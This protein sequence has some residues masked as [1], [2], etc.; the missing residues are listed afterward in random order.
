MRNPALRLLCVLS[1]VVL[2]V[3]PL[4]ADENENR[5]RATLR[6]MQ[7]VGTAAAARMT[8]TNV[9]PDVAS[10][11]ALV[12]LLTPTYLPE[13]PLRDGWDTPLRYV[14][15]GPQSFQ[16]VSAGAD[17][18][19]DEKS[20]STA[21]QSE[22]LAA[23]AVYLVKRQ[24]DPG[25]FHRFWMA[26]GGARLEFDDDA[27]RELARPLVDAE[28]EKMKGMSPRQSFSYLRTS[29]TLRDME[30][31][32][33]FLDVYRLK[34]GRYP[35]AASMAELEPML[36][37]EF[38]SSVPKKDKWG[39]ELRYVPSPDGKSYRLI[40][41]GEDALF[42]ETS[43]AKKGWLASADDDAVVE[44][45]EI[46]RRWTTETQPGFGPRAKLQPKA[47]ALLAEADARLEAQDHAGAL[48][49][50]IDA[51][52]ADRAA[53]DLEALRRYAPPAFEVTAP[54]PESRAAATAAHIAALRQFLELHPGNADAE[55]DLVLLLPDAEAVA[56]AGEIVKRRPRDAEA[57]RLRSQLRFRAGQH[58]EALADLEHATT[59]EPGNGE[60]FYTAGVA[61]Y[62][63]VAKQEG[64]STQQKR[65]LVRR[66]F[67]AFDRA[68]ALRA[69]YF[70]SLSYRSL[71][72]REQAKLES[73][74]A[75][76]RKL[77]EEADA[78]RQRA[79][80]ILKAKRL[81]RN[82]PG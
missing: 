78:V 60:L 23:D 67:A 27:I 25:S 11:E 32:G 2:A 1:F 81:P 38:A 76:Q 61:A 30:V 7:S 24:Y 31:V 73:D 16:I 79:L 29:S 13:V 62:E 52:K 51:V 26:G 71:L 37:P 49:A 3:P 36:F 65:D 59:L 8:D 69:D 6:R 44:N 42:D 64:L 47:R 70:E 35:A 48:Q 72:L 56:F 57:Y 54:A 22:D 68:E 66:G 17:R 53:A 41:A 74:P 63:L 80:E 58:M 9:A 5:A 21:A 34:Y 18:Q 77:T 45:G 14:R 39:T 43:W 4:P 10:I 15:L 40:S 46:V 75:V 55:R 12:P 20:W 19:F 33:L 28:I 50:Y 82:P